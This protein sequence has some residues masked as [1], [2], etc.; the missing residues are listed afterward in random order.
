MG[1][2]RNRISGKFG[3][4]GST[5]E[6]SYRLLIFERDREK[7]SFETTGMKDYIEE[8]GSF[9]SNSLNIEIERK[10]LRNNRNWKYD[11]TE[12]NNEKN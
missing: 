6:S 3:F 4:A 11:L 5:T 9:I 8:L 12:L 2:Y 1:I 10:A 7:P